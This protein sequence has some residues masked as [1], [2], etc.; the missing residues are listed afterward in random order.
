L[1]GSYAHLLRGFVPL[2]RA[3]GISEEVVHTMLVEN[4]KQV[5]AIP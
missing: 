2:L 3:T 1:S 5:L 4:P